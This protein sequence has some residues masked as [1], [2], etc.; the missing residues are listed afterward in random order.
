MMIRT[1]SLTHPFLS[2]RLQSDHLV[3]SLVLTKDDLKDVMERLATLT[4]LVALRGVESDDV[5]NSADDQLRRLKSDLAKIREVTV[6]IIQMIDEPLEERGIDVNPLNSSNLYNV[7]NTPQVVNWKPV[8]RMG[9]RPFALTARV[10]TIVAYLAAH[11]IPLAMGPTDDIIQ[12]SNIE[13]QGLSDVFVKIEQMAD[14]L[15]ASVPG[16]PLTSEVLNQLATIVRAC[17]PPP[18]RRV[19]V[20]RVPLPVSRAVQLRL[21]AKN[22]R[23]THQE[24]TR[25]Y[26][27][28]IGKIG[29]RGLRPNFDSRKWVRTLENC[30]E[31]VGEVISSITKYAFFEEDLSD[32]TISY[33]Q[34]TT[35][36]TLVF[37]VDAW[38]T[39]KLQVL[40]NTLKAYPTTCDI[41]STPAEGNV[42][43]ELS[44][45]AY[46]LGYDGETFA[47]KLESSGDI[48]DPFFE[49][50]DRYWPS[51]QL[52]HPRL[53]T[54]VVRRH[55]IHLVASL[56]D[57][58]GTGMMCPR[59]VLCQTGA[60]DDD[61]PD[62]EI[63]PL[64]TIPP[65][66]RPYG[67]L[68]SWAEEMLAR[69]RPTPDTPATVVL[70]PLELSRE[71]SWAAEMFA[72]PELSSPPPAPD[73]PEAIALAFQRAELECEL[74]V[75]DERERA[76][77]EELRALMADESSG[78]DGGGDGGVSVPVFQRQPSNSTKRPTDSAGPSTVPPKK[79]KKTLR[80]KLAQAEKKP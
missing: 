5:V 10:R 27:A 31:G 32:S 47:T 74:E 73:T 19:E 39:D 64:L 43:C 28:V 67:E 79:K 9:K 65:L 56:P 49:L 44:R 38:A 61:E 54:S 13:V 51:A 2:T 40:F 36:A 8:S 78:D 46:L 62:D 35:E 53:M 58:F 15:Q 29:L 48:K 63:M 66:E 72:R 42:T 12:L 71:D 25:R 7:L 22:P 26:S 37:D 45:L 75:L 76:L 14:V 77:Q 11:Q 70:P 80:E 60:D 41:E 59:H 68:E 21:P 17:V 16:A 52:I 57:G 33:A 23:L 20:A 4:D 30:Y 34:G 50:F 55:L 18:G 24:A 1:Y 3:R 69:P 6:D